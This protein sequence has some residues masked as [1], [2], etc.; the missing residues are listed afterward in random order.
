MGLQAD[1]VFS[2]EQERKYL[3]QNTSIYLQVQTHL[4][5]SYQPEYHMSF[6]GVQKRLMKIIPDNI[7]H[8]FICKMKDLS[9]H[10][11]VQKMQ[12]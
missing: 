1:T 12:Q 8:L 3:S 10:H 2:P 11:V 7:Y 4:R 6:H 9:Q 5:N